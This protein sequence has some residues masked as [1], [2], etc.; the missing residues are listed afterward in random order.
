MALLGS[1][2]LTASAAL[3]G[4]SYAQPAP[5]AIATPR[6]PALWVLNAGSDSSFTPNISIFQATKLNRKTGTVG[7]VGFRT[8]KTA[9]GAMG[10]DSNHDLWL[11]LCVGL[12]QA[13]VLVELT[14]AGLRHLVAYGSAKFSVIIQDPAATANHA[15][16]FLSCPQAL[17]FDPL[18]N[19]WVAPAD[20]YYGAGT[21]LLEYSSSELLSSGTPVPAAVIET[22]TPAEYYGRIALAFDHSGNLWQSSGPIVEYTAA[23]LAAGIQTDPNQTLTVGGNYPQLQLPSSITFDAGGNLWVAMR[24]GGTN[25]GGGLE[26]FAAADLNGSGMVTPTPAIT[27]TSSLY[28]TKNLLSSFDDPN[29]LAFDSLGDLWVG[30]TLQPEA[31]LGAG[32]LVEFSAS[33][34]TASGSPVPIRAILSKHRETNL[35][36][37]EFMTFGPALP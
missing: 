12:L 18:D 19:L 25:G 31:G 8:S 9:V 21:P 27:L 35:Y 17:Q 37:P 22:P 3:A 23:Q 14:P 32:S 13:G 36:F 29:A 24:D 34:L 2:A 28:G 26:M 30:N 15:P 5:Q 7:A 1:A 11:G 20:I 16:E 6:P 10:F 4:K 33:E